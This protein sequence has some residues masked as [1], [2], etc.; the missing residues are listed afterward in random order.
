MSSCTWV[1]Y[2]Y[3]I[4]LDDVIITEDVKKINKFLDY[5]P[6]YKK[7]VL[8]VFADNDIT[9]PVFSDYEELDG[10]WYLGIA[11]LIKEVLTE[12]SGIVFT[13]C[14]DAG[15]YKYVMYCQNFP[16][17][18]S[19]AEKGLTKEKLS[20]IMSIMGIIVENSEKLSFS[21]VEAENYG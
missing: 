8:E 2:G 16:W 11:T 1:N 9:E 7:G 12:Y 17:N 5:A 15:G 10:D 18:M 6:E 3:G 21:E 19:E 14:G 13:A 4:K 20:E